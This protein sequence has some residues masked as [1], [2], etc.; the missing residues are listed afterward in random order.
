MMG[1]AKARNTRYRV[2]RIYCT[3]LTRRNIVKIIDQKCLQSDRFFWFGQ[4]SPIRPCL[5]RASEKDEEFDR[6]SIHHDI[7]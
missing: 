7:C 6:F 5:R 4:L 3:S 2:S 1:E